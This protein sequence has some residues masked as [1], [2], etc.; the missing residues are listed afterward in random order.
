MVL[1]DSVIYIR[2]SIKWREIIIPQVP[3]L[4]T[5][6]SP[7]LFP[8]SPLPLL[9]LAFH[10]DF[11]MAQERQTMSDISCTEQPHSEGVP[12][13]R[14]Q[15]SPPN[16]PRSLCFCSFACFF[17][18]RFLLSSYRKASPSWKTYITPFPLR[19]WTRTALW[20]AKTSISWDI[21]RLHPFR[22]RVWELKTMTGNYQSPLEKQVSGA[23]ATIYYYYRRWPP[24]WSPFMIPAILSLLMN[25]P[26][27]FH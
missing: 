3:A 12:L 1:P 27:V 11:N 2:T 24:R 13:C 19:A 26:F 18:C 20:E 22:E 14:G 7:A 10:L 8:P 4:L 15:E 25:L 17:P 5:D 21:N 9:V 16:H 6:F 23:M